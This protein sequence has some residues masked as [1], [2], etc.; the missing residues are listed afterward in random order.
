MDAQAQ[1]RAHRIGQTREVHI[2]RFVSG[3]TI[4]ENILTKA[5]QKRHLDHLVMTEGNFSEDSLFSADGLKGILGVDEQGSSSSDATSSDKKSTNGASDSKSSTAGD[6]KAIAEAMAAVEDEE[7]IQACKGAVEELKKEQIE[8]D[9]SVPLPPSGEGESDGTGAITASDGSSS[10]SVV[11]TEEADAEKEFNSW[12]ASVG[13]DFNSLQ[14]ALKPIERYA[15]QHRTV[16]EPYYSIHF[17]SEQEKLEAM[18]ASGALNAAGEEWDVEEI[19]MEKERQEMK[20]LTEGELLYTGAYPK[21]ITSN[22]NSNGS[23][24]VGVQQRL[25]TGRELKKLHEWYI[26][27]RGIKKQERKRRILSGDAWTE[28]ID[29]KTGFPFWYN[30]DTGESTAYKPA[31]LVARE[32]IVLARKL[33][34]GGLPMTILLHVFSFLDPHPDR[35]HASLSCKKWQLAFQD[36]C[37][38][39][40]VLPV[41]SG[42]KDNAERLGK[43]KTN[44]FTSIKDAIDAS[45]A[46]QVIKIGSGHHWETE[47]IAI[48]HPIKL[49]SEGGESSRC[50]IELATNSSLNIETSKG[51]VYISGVTLRR[52]RR[53]NKPCNCIR[54]VNS[55][56]FVYSSTVD[57]EGAPGPC[58]YAGHGGHL[59]LLNCSVKHGHY[60]GI[61][62][63]NARVILSFC[64]VSAN[65]LPFSLLLSMYILSN[66]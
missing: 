1:D 31:I 28:Y 66:V 55:K 9:E 3:S 41:E 53:I 2:Y 11:N 14:A 42:M 29:D 60:A 54:I 38:E 46:G 30:K 63:M 58:I 37:F 56:C 36:H 50:I 51:L 13:P 61:L 20:L 34:Y 15:L 7:D 19:E 49:L 5:R 40:T 59:S 26:K 6:T 18:K 48:K 10:T 33:K 43:L 45:T 44:E 62:T 64:N 23:V 12:Q 35:Y 32:E 16:A 25:P 22:S 39:F 27:E 17:L 4:E 65:E 8:F 21:A 24:S 57:N 47:P 52:A